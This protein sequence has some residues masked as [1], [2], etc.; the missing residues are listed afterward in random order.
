MAFLPTACT[1]PITKTL[2]VNF[3]GSSPA[4][5]N[6]Y[7]V[8]WKTASASTYNIVSPNPTSSPVTITN[9]PVCEN[10]T[11]VM[12]SQCD[13]SQ[14]SAEQTTTVT[15]S[16]M[17]T[18][19]GT[20]SGSHTHNGYYKYADYILDCSSAAGD[21]SLAYDT[22][23]KPNRFAVFDANGNEVV[24]SGWRGVAN[25][26]GPWGATL[27]TALTG[28]ISFTPTSCWYKLVVE[29][30]TDTSFTDTFT[31]GMT[32]LTG[33][34][35]PIPTITYG[36]CSSGVGSYTITAPYGTTMKVAITASGQLTNT[37]VNGYCSRLEAAMASSTGPSL[38]AV[39][40]TVSGSGGASIGSSNTAYLTL[41]IPVGG[42]LNISTNVK[43]INSTA[44]MTSGSIK[45]I[46]INGTDVTS[47]NYTQS[48]CVGNSTGTVSCSSSPS[49]TYPT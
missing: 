28:T 34:A 40:S 5:S 13:N 18:C 22:V 35:L 24:S 23:D 8:K 3:T 11:V 12:Q 44:S 14:V 16:T 21:I 45:I 48:I 27:N 37:G 33:S 20:I 15:K 9:V 39:S 32:C 49:V 7:I 41:T 4:P 1:C 17:Y 43:T 30:V 36:G 19:A 10:I 46:E 47:S 6:G 26:T 25:Y 42:Y 31:V 38:L 2:T 29:S